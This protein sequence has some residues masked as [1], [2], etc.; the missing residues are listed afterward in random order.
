MRCAQMAVQEDIWSTEHYT[1]SHIYV[2]K[3][4]LPR[5]PLRATGSM[6]I[7]LPE[8]HVEK[9]RKAPDVP[10]WRD[11]WSL[12]IILAQIFGSKC[13]AQMSLPWCKDIYMEGNMQSSY[14]DRI[15]NIYEK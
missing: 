13:Q 15:H 14:T 7:I 8:Y 1:A 10:S 9:M 2:E 4:A 12:N 3:M 11:I 6:N 5:C